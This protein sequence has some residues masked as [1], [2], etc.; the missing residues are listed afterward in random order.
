[1]MF[2]RSVETIIQIKEILLPFYIATNRLQKPDLTLSDGYEIWLTVALALAEIKANAHQKTNL[3]DTLLAELERRQS[4]VL[5]N[6]AL[7]AHPRIR[8]T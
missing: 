6:R 4:S 5:E 1:M 3:A 2:L 8:V 7:C